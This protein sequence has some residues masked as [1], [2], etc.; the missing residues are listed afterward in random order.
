MSDLQ[1]YLL[2]FDPDDNFE[3]IIHCLMIEYKWL[4]DKLKAAGD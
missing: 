4:L 1:M 3:F 2:S